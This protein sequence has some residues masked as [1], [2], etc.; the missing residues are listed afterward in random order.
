MSRK[1]YVEAARIIRE[2]H[3]TKETRKRLVARFVTFFA[4]DNPRFSPSRFREACTPSPDEITAAWYAADARL[5]ER[6]QDDGN[7]DHGQDDP[8]TDV[9]K[10]QGEG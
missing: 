10:D 9:R 1:D 8:S 4:D 5:P 6:G 2:E 3:M 7:N